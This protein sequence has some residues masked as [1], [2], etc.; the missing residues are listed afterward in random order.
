M[1]I[2][3]TTDGTRSGKPFAGTWFSVVDWSLTLTA[4]GYNDGWNGPLTGVNSINAAQGA[5]ADGIYAI[6]GRRVSNAA[7]GLYIV[8]RNG[9]ANKVIVK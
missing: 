8:V 3:Q 4:K 7:R 1:T 2:G 6:D 5:A 9:K